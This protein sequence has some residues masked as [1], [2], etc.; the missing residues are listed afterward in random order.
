MQGKSRG[1]W[2]TTMGVRGRQV[3]LC[4]ILLLAALGVQPAAAGCF[5]FLNAGQQVFHVSIDALDLA[6]CPT[7]VC[8][9]TDLPPGGREE[10][11]P[12]PMVLPLPPPPGA[13]PI[14]QRILLKLGNMTARDGVLSGAR[15][16]FTCEVIVRNPANYSNSME[17]YGCEAVWGGF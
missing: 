11:C 16:N 7:G 15:R 13:H 3:L 12:G 9:Q 6:A 2:R 14:E 8:W 17:S 10:Y 1:F 5:R 4:T